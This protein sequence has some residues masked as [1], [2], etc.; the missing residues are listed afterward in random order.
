[1]TTIPNYKV[2]AVYLDPEREGQVSREWLRYF[3]DLAE[4]P[5]IPEVIAVG[6]SPFTYQVAKRGAV[7]IAG[8][9]VTK[10][11]L[12]RLSTFT[13][14]GVTSGQVQALMNDS[15]RITYSAAPVMTLLPV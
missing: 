1:M 7:V 14:L 5:L 2:P 13:D 6:A 15:V 10:V 12:G 3:Q 4:K 9:T 8:G 11:E